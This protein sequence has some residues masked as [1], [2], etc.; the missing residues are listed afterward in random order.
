MFHTLVR[1]AFSSLFPWTWP[2]L[3]DQRQ[4]G[5]VLSDHYGGSSLLERPISA[6]P[7]HPVPLLRENHL[8]LPTFPKRQ[9]QDI[10]LQSLFSLSIRH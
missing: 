5:T 9:P 8:G 1:N 4:E 10:F 7:P 2:F 3:V 6:F